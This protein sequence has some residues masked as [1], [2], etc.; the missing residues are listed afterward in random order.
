MIE[1]GMLTDK[2]HLNLICKS[3]LTLNDRIILDMQAGIWMK[4]Y[5]TARI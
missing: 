2:W 1:A 4:S 5:G 3:Q